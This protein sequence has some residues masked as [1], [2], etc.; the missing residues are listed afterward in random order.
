[1][2]IR[3]TLHWNDR[4]WLLK[5]RWPLNVRSNTARFETAFGIVERPTYRNTSWQAAQFEVAGHRFADLSEPGYGVA[6]LNDGK[7]GHH[8]LGNEVGLSLLR[9]PTYPD[10]IADEGPQ[11]FTYA[12]L[13]HEGDWLDGG[14]LAEAEDL[15]RPLLCT[16]VRSARDTVVTP[17]SFQGLPLG[18]G[19]LKS[20]E[21][22]SGLVLRAYEPRGA[23]GNVKLSLP[24]GWA[25]D[26]ELN[27]LE[28]RTGEPQTH[29]TPFKLR[30]WLL[31]REG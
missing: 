29:F 19:A 6:L 24:E 25:L 8:A 10:P 23:R 27:L 15:N 1:M 20:S 3:T 12:V 4:R 28:K 26:S 17:V 30:S 7:Y 2:D 13:P 9:S 31:K 16:R 21:D 5:S 22:R 18:L 11:T 14:V